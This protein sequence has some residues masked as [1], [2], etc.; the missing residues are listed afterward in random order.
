MGVLFLSFGG[1]GAG[2][3]KLSGWDIYFLVAARNTPIGGFDQI[4]LLL[5]FG[6]SNGKMLSAGGIS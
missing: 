2:C 5:L 1:W 3:F 6:L 4:M